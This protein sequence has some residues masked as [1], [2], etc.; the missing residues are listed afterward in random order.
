MLDFQLRGLPCRTTSVQ[1]QAPSHEFLE[2][3]E[4]SSMPV[5]SSYPL[6][7]AMEVENPCLL[8][9]FLSLYLCATA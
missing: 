8:D 7:N 2:G 3:L 1:S 9:A 6:E 5:S 4:S